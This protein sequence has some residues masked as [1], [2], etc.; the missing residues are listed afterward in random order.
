MTS[1]VTGTV[2]VRS[3][4]RRDEGLIP[5]NAPSVVRNGSTRT[6]APV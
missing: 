3:L 6:L 4:G 5:G 1:L 2:I